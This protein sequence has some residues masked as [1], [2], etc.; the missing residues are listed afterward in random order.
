MG[1]W[2]FYGGVDHWIDLPKVGFHRYL[3][4]VGSGVV[5]QKPDP[6]RVGCMVVVVIWLAGIGWGVVYIGA[7]LVGYLVDR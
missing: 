1:S 6:L 5:V 7:F 2:S 4:G 3:A